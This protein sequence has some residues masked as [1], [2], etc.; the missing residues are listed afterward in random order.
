VISSG[1][2]GTALRPTA[3]KT[4]EPPPRLQLQSSPESRQVPLSRPVRR[5]VCTTFFL[6]INRWNAACS[7]ADPSATDGPAIRTPLSVVGCRPE[8]LTRSARWSTAQEQWLSGTNLLG[9]V[10][11]LHCVILRS[12]VP[13]LLCLTSVV[14]AGRYCQE[15]VSGTSRRSRKQVCSRGEDGTNARRAARK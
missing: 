15:A 11:N 4:P 13:L 14:V 7:S 8:L 1:E 2:V 6:F 9:P 10:R 5:C 12:R 3:F